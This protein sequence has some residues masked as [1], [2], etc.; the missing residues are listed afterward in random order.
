MP[1]DPEAFHPHGL[2][3][4]KPVATKMPCLYLDGT[5]DYAST[6]DA[7]TAKYLLLDG[8]GDYISTPDHADFDITGDIDM[9]IAAALDDWTPPAFGN[10]DL[11]SKWSPVGQRSYYLRADDTGGLKFGWSVIGGDEQS[12]VSTDT[13]PVSDGEGLLV[14]A[15]FDVDDGAGNY[16]VTFYSK[17]F[18]Y[19]TALADLKSNEGWDQL[20]DPVEAVGSMTMFESSSVVR[21]GSSGD[22]YDLDGKVYAVCIYNGIDTNVGG[23]EYDLTDNGSTTDEQGHTW[24]LQ[25]GA[26]FAEQYAL[27][28]S[29]D[30]TIDV[31]AAVA[32]TDW[33]RSSI[34]AAAAIASKLSANTGWEFGVADAASP[35]ASF[36]AGRLYFAYGTGAATT[37]KQST[38][39][40]APALVADNS[41]LLVRA[42][43][44]GTDVR[45]Y[46]R[47]FRPNTFEADIADDTIAAGA[48][49]LL[50]SAVAAT[51][52]VSGS[53]AVLRV[54]SRPDGTL[55]VDGRVWGIH[56]KRGGASV[57][58]PNF[59]KQTDRAADFTDDYGHVWSMNADA[60][61]QPNY[62][63]DGWL[64]CDGATL[65]IAD[66]PDLFEAIGNGFGGD[67]VTTF[68]VPDMTGRVPLGS[69]TPGT[70]GAN[71]SSIGSTTSVAVADHTLNTQSN[72]T[73]TGGAVRVTGPTPLGHTAHFHTLPYTNI[74]WLIW[75]L[76][77]VGEQVDE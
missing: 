70:G 33:D 3:D 25:G 65:D 71:A 21:V 47:K 40:V 72:T 28:T 63:M 11:V 52:A 43:Y 6:P 50:G 46:T 34:A 8:S 49:V 60:Y 9:R 5:D 15:T 20:G 66:Y 74:G 14:R 1:Y 37:Y 41:A 26:S 32:L 17:E 2:G 38:S 64:F 73:I 10:L 39:A 58:S 35:D 13:L 18:I 57:A 16:V 51:G 48:W 42:K 56:L 45:F 53:S 44:D 54:G 24:T 29:S 77:P 31:R 55:D 62:G 75:H 27:D 69:L 30:T 61:M 59:H 67:G 76:S 36:S 23:C 68:A 19:D 22:G 4:L 7:G 12:A